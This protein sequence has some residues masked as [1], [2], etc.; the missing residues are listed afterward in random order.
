MHSLGVSLIQPSTSLS[1][2]IDPLSE[3]QADPALET[4]RVLSHH[5][6]CRHTPYY[7]RTIVTLTH[8]YACMPAGG[9][10]A[11]LSCQSELDIT[12]FSCQLQKLTVLIKHLQALPGLVTLTHTHTHLQLLQEGPL[13]EVVHQQA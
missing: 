9:K 7:A 8:T 2:P 1:P 6:D 13:A 11:S 5:H 12:M 3:R 4:W 10:T